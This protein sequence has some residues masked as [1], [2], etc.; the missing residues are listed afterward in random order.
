MIIKVKTIKSKQ[1]ITHEGVT[2]ISQ[3]KRGDVILEFGPGM[4]GVVYP[5]K[6]WVRFDRV[7][8]G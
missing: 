5:H 1:P 6:V 7:Q 3:N 8:E 4:A 2:R